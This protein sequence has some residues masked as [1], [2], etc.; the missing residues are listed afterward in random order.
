MN[1]GRAPLFSVVIPT[2]NR[3]GRLSRTMDSVLKQTFA[4]FELLV[5]DDGSSDGTREMVES[6]TDPRI[7]YEWAPNSGGPAVPRNRGIDMACGDWIAFL[8]ADDFWYPRK[9]EVVAAAIAELPDVVAVC[10][11]EYRHIETSG[12]RSLLCHG[13]YEDDFYRVMLTQGN[14]VS[15]SA[16]TV[17]RD[18]L[19]HHGLRFNTSRDYAIVEDYDLWLRIALSGGR[20]HFIDEPLGEYVIEGDNLTSNFER[21]H[22]NRTRLLYD[23]VF[24]VQSFEPNRQKL[25]RTMEVRLAIQS[26][27]ELLRKRGFLSAASELITALLKSPRS[28]AQYFIWWRRRRARHSRI[29]R[30]VGAVGGG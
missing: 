20:Y 11:N 1:A 10:H 6:Y 9:L 16:V 19:A 22:R 29:E 17:R 14:R 15:T 7:R 5:M 23:H 28:L 25:W 30:E 27:R 13:P 12:E 2:Y 18:F 21:F 26:S 8:D 4:D 24:A 3:R